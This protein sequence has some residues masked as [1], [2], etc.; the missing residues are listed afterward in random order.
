MKKLL[1][2]GLTLVLVGSLV[3]CG[4][5][6]NTEDTAET[7]SQTEETETEETEEPEE[8]TVETVEPEVEE[9][10]E[11]LLTYSEENG[12]I[13]SEVEDL[14]NISTKVFFG[15]MEDD[16]DVIDPPSY[17][18]Y[19]ES[20]STYIIEGISVTP[21]EEEGY[22]DVT[23]NSS[24]SFPATIY[25][26]SNYSTS[27]GGFAFNVNGFAFA[28]YYTGI[29]FPDRAVSNNDSFEYS[30]DLEWE[31]ETYTISYSTEQVIES[32]E[33]IWN[34]ENPENP[35][36]WICSNVFTMNHTDIVTIPE[37]YDGLVMYLLV[38][39]ALA[40]DS[41]EVDEE[42]DMEVSYLLESEDGGINVADDYFCIRINV[43]DYME[44][45]EASEE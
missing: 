6:E 10:P 11:V 18:T 21:S 15:Y 20:D 45:E 32:D 25:V 24:T 27:T 3:A 37:G 28:D 26:D 7:E 9:E 19:G 12:L 22:L 43:S 36:I 4:S 17:I 38:A 44:V 34:Y 35:D 5:S 8:E 31:E 41:L 16:V 30:I 33:Y 29:E 2:L 42:I 13:F 14:E 40:I 39:D 23:V 1:I